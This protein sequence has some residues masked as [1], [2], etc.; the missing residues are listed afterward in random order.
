M[1]TLKRVIL[2]GTTLYP[3][4]IDVDDQRIALG[5][6][7]M[8]DG[9]LRMWHRAFKRKWTLHWNSLPEAL[10]PAIRTIYRTT[11]SMTYND[12]DNANHTVVSISKTENLAADRISR[13]GIMYYDVDL[14]IEEV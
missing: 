12:E 7:R 1:T 4:T 5:P 14:V 8:I 3:T 11:A 2:G 10:L 9:T 6:E 13:A